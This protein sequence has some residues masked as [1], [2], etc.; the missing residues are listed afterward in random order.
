MVS[1]LVR[2]LGLCSLLLAGCT[3]NSIS[4]AV[5]AG[6]PGWVLCSSSAQCPKALPMCDPAA[7]VCT[8]CIAWLGCASGMTCNVATHSCVPANPNAPCTGNFDCPR[9]A[10]DAP[11]NIVCQPTTGRCVQCVANTDCVSGAC[12]NAGPAPT[13]TCVGV[14]G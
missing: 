3:D 9:P 11:G 2:T 10:L 5:D 7:G 4:P 13:F 12:D 1:A 8:G 6:D 14:P